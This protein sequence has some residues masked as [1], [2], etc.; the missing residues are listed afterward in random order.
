MP[1]F[2]PEVLFHIFSLNI[3]N[4]LLTALIVFFFV[5]I[6]I[7]IAGINI[8][9]NRLSKL[10]LATELIYEGL[11]GNIRD[12]IG[13]PSN[14]LI[15]FV[16]TFFIMILSSNW[17]GLLPFV[18]SVGLVENHTQET[19]SV[20]IVKDVKASATDL[21]Y[22]ESHDLSF[23]SCVKER[24]C[25]INLS[26]LKIQKV[27]HMLHLFRAPTADV[28]FTLTLAVLSIIGIT[29]IG[30][31]THGFSYFKKFFDF[32]GPIQAFVGILELISEIS[33][34]I[35]FTFRLFGNIYAGEVLI[36]VMTSLTYGIATIPFILLEF[37][38]GFIQAFVFFLLT[39]VFMSLAMAHH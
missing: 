10:Q 1:S 30:I 39:T 20:N 18:P 36:F 37:F 34:I 32:S 31:G 26:T 38:V 19:H 21:E 16:I 7:I 6:F 13:K 11:A 9:K 28:S 23:I 27:S 25:V 14:T 3:T 17:F 24:N 2:T 4:S 15:S 35:S 12:I 5:S 22:V 33:K 8:R 29:I